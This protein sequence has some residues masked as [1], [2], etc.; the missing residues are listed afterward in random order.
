V[1]T[2]TGYS[3]PVSPYPGTRHADMT[4][5]DTFTDRLKPYWAYL[6]ILSIACMAAGCSS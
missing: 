2:E 6:G 5:T 1:K 4:N 3:N